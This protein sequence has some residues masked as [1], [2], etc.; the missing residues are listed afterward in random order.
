ML[1][2]FVP[3]AFPA[4]DQGQYYRKETALRIARRVM[5]TFCL[6]LTIHL[7]SM[8]EEN[9]VPIVAINQFRYHFPAYLVNA[10]TVFGSKVMSAPVRVITPNPCAIVTFVLPIMRIV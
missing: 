4:S 5:K 1:D 3:R 7:H 6:N 10:Y 8:K 9:C 2:G